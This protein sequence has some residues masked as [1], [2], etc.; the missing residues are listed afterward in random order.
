M[1]GAGRGVQGLGIMRWGVGFKVEELRSRVE[2]LGCRVW[3]L[4][5]MVYGL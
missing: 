5:F 1:Y 3:V 2:G 4:G